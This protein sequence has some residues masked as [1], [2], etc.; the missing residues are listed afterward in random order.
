MRYKKTRKY[1]SLRKKKRMY[2]LKGRNILKG[3]NISSGIVYPPFEINNYIKHIIYINLDK[4]TDRNNSIIDQL[5]IFDNNK[6]TRVSGIYN[7]NN[8]VLGCALSH[9]N[10]L[11]LAREKKYPHV[12]ILEDD[13]IWSDVNAS[14][15]IFKILMDK[16]FVQNLYDVI[17]L[18]GSGKKFDPG[19][20]R[21]EY[22]QAASSYLVNGLYYDKIISAIEKELNNKRIDPA[23]EA[24]NKNVD[25]IYLELQKF[26]KW[27]IVYPSL[28][29]QGKSH[30]DILGGNVDYK[31]WFNSKE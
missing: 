28:M 2:S 1:K 30:S 25:I 15:P 11:K 10:A 19:T 31:S 21:V 26:D 29:I 9:L 16:L 27:Y 7:E 13:A 3:G 18:G 23:D 6:I 17:M 22:A 12:L 5:K 8:K 4:R 24:Y 20:Y 14:Y